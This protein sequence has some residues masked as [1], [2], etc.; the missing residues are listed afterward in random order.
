MKLT[1][2][3]RIEYGRIVWQHFIQKRKAVQPDMR[4]AEYDIIRRWMDR[5]IP[6][7]VVLRGIADCK[8]KPRTLMGCE[9]AVEDAIRYYFQAIGGPPELPKAGPLEDP[10]P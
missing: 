2:E 10:K 8:G 9:A 6:L 3:E 1:A 4:T 7:A 5:G